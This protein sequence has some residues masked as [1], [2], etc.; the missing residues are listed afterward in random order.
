MIFVGIME[1]GQEITT[2]FPDFYEKD[3]VA[4][5]LSKG[6]WIRLKEGEMLMEIG[7]NVKY[8]P[9]LF[10]G[11]LKVLR[12]DKDGNELLLYYV[13]PGES[14]AMTLS[15]CLGKGLS[16]VR[17]VVEE[18]CRVLLIPVHQVENWTARH[19]S[20]KIFVMHTYHRRFE[21]LLR[22]IDGIA[23]HKLDDR[24]MNLLDQRVKSTGS[25]SIQVTHQELAGEL[26]SSR[27]VISRILKQ[28]EKKGIVTLG[29]SR[30]EVIKTHS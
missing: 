11:S 7:A 20:W 10:E 16:E 8:V 2:V 14:C 21:E 30:I 9:L 3:L 13:N 12:E 24:L 26:N 19:D 23:F 28:L 17:A 25:K 6:S 18:D 29:R 15:S 27:E 5:I 4:E 22:T 1:I